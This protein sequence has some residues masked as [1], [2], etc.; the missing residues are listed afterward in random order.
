MFYCVEYANKDPLEPIT[1]SSYLLG[2]W[3]SI[4]I[5]YWTSFNTQ[6]SASWRKRFAAVSRWSSTGCTWFCVKYQRSKAAKD[7]ET[8]IHDWRGNELS[9]LWI[10]SII[11]CNTQLLCSH[12]NV[13]KNQ[14]FHHVI[15]NYIF[16]SCLVTTHLSCKRKS[17]SKTNLWLIQWEGELIIGV[18]K[19][20]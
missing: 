12:I 17:L 14:Y 15:F 9:P 5:K 3:C 11:S 8:S 19:L 16:R 18:I 20:Y 1:S 13:L 10:Y 6:D 2:R 4:R 7:N